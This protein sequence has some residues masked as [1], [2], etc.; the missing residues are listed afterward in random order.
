MTRSDIDIHSDFI[1]G[2]TKT[3]NINEIFNSEKELRIRK[4]EWKETLMMK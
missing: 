2:D 4:K 1:L 3:Q